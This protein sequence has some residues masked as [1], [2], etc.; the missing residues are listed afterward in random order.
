MYSLLLPAPPVA[1]RS[2]CA[3]RAAALVGGSRRVAL[4]SELSL[5][6]GLSLCLFA[7]RGMATA[8]SDGRRATQRTA[9]C[10]GRSA[11][12]GGYCYYYYI[13]AWR[14]KTRYC[15]LLV[16]PAPPLPPPPPLPPAPAPPLPP[17]RAPP[18]QGW[19]RTAPVA[20]QLPLLAAVERA[21]A[22]APRAGSWWQSGAARP[23]LHCSGGGGVFLREVWSEACRLAQRAGWKYGRAPRLGRSPGSPLQAARLHP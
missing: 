12:H 5:P 10:G 11:V 21:V 1:R 8:A 6:D 18:P 9:C 20:G 3:V 17:A 7:W 14:R 13:A 23:R 16:D 2:Q 19:R 4:P 22:P 15:A